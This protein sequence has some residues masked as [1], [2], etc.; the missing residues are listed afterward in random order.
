MKILV[1]SPIKWDGSGNRIEQIFKRIAKKHEVIVLEPAE[2]YHKAEN[3]IQNIKKRIIPETYMKDNI[4]FYTKIISTKRIP[5][6]IWEAMQE[7]QK[8]RIINIE[9]PE[10]YVYMTPLDNYKTIKENPEIEKIFDIADYNS[11]LEIRKNIEKCK[12][13]EEKCIKKSDKIIAINEILAEQAKQHKKVTIIPNGVDIKYLRNVKQRTKSEKKNIG[14]V[15]N[16]AEWVDRFTIEYI[17]DKMK[18]CNI[19]IIGKGLPIKQ[20]IN[21]IQKGHLPYEQVKEEINNFDIGIIPFNK[22]KVARYSMPLKLYEYAA[23][24]KP[25]VSSEI[26]TIKQYEGKG[27]YIYRRKREIIPKIK[28]ALKDKTKIKWIEKYDWNKIV[29][30]YIKELER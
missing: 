29:K 23:L 6:I 27:V 15:G 22:T 13:A 24:N 9:K 10:K 3:K 4:K 25:T 26:E 20:K 8:R 16:I 19:T 30:K 7:E 28:Q 21:I 12:K 18:N 1:D 11:G 14:F 17:A 5:Q 2:M